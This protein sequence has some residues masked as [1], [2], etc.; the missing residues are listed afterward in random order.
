MSSTTSR[1]MFEG[2]GAPVNLERIDGNI[3]PTLDSC[4]RREVRAIFSGGRGAD[5]RAS[6]ADVVVESMMRACVRDFRIESNRKRGAVETALRSHDRIAR[7]EGQRRRVGGGGGAVGVGVGGGGGG[8]R[9]RPYHSAFN[10][11]PNVDFDGDGCRCCYDPN[12]DGG[13][14]DLL[15]RAREDGT[16]GRRV[17]VGRVG[18]GSDEDEDEEKRRRDGTEDSDDSDSDSDD[19]EFDYLLDEDDGPTNDALYDDDGPMA[20]RRAELVDVVRRLEAARCHGYG[21]HRQMSP[22][23][24]FAAAGHRRLRLLGGRD[25][26]V[27]PPPRGSVL[28][29]FDPNSTLSASLDLCLEDLARRHPGTKF[30]R[31]HGVASIAHASASVA[32]GGGGCSDDD[33]WRRADLPMLLALRDGAIVAW[34]SGLRDFRDGDGTGVET[35]AVERWLDRA[36]AL[37]S[38]P[39]PHPDE[40]CG[41]RPEEDALLDG[42]RRLNGIGRRG[43]GTKAEEDSDDG[44]HD[45]RY[46]CGVAGCDKSFYHEHVGIKTDAQDGLLVSESQVASASTDT[47]S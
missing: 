6:F 22:S 3:D 36:G 31:G 12:G 17:V 20:R 25:D 44:M 4:C 33:G 14:Y 30:V 1:Q 23:R 16:R 2:V 19:G 32:A 42:M 47:V 11:L 18:A 37:I 29:L 27:R 7:I 46:P 39:P 9:Y 28:H 10:L 38:D 24:V 15:T 45:D 21:V 26:D 8:G 35:D 43:G 5:E 40:L 41:I 13:E 34:S